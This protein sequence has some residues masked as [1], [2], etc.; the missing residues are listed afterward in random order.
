ML[1][2]L[3]LVWRNIWRNR[4]RSAISLASVLFA[5]LIALVMRSMQLGF[6]AKS[7]DNVVSF[8]TGY[9]EVHEN[10]YNA[11]QSVNLS[12]EE[13]APLMMAVRSRPGVTLAAP[14]LETFGLLSGE[15][16]T[17]GGLTVG[18]N[19]ATEDSL[20][21]LSARVTKGRYLVAG[22]VGIL[23][24]EGLA[25]YLETGVGDTV[26]VLG[27]GYHGLMAVGKYPVIGL[28]HFPTNELNSGLA[29]ITLGQARELTGAYGRLTSIAIMLKN[30]G[31]LTSVAA[32]LRAS[33]GPDF[34][35]L[36][37][38]EVMPELVQFIQWDNASGLIMLAIIYVVI[39]F[40]ILGTV[41]MMTMERM[42]EFGMLISVG[43]KRSWLQ[44][45]VFL[46]SVI[47][48]FAGAVAGALIAIPIIAHFH[49]HPLYMSGTAAEATVEFGF[50]PIM[51]FLLAPGLF[52]NQGLVVL[53]IAV[54]A[55]LYP[56]LRIATLDPVSAMRR[57]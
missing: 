7:I 21:G 2:Y 57:P 32:G 13:T 4:R 20:T 11:E 37:W 22:D 42:H 45:V 56:I 12:F 29:F 38:E 40:G 16:L 52:L 54:A 50:E 8:Y 44:G 15:N 53:A 46:E 51:P 49:A 5:V 23:L 33:L 3:N 6:Y 31:D 9:I 47:L 18:I 17:S 19:P 41:L 55:S 34:E 26:V 36:T 24:A 28:V 25:D 43:M 27:Q 35:V 39:G 10:G 1:M 14:R 48:S 30:Q